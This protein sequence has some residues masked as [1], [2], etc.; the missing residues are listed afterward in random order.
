[1]CGCEEF[2]ENYEYQGISGN[3]VYIDGFI[4]EYPIQT[5]DEHK[6][7]NFLPR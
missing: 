2:L 1:M 3:I 6:D 4:P 7:G 5:T